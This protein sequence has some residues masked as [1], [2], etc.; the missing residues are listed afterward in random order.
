MTD[1]L[2][3]KEVV[4]KLD[5]RTTEEHIQNHYRDIF[6]LYQGIFVVIDNGV[7]LFN[8]KSGATQIAADATANELWTTD[9]HA[10]LP[11]NVVMMGV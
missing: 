11:D 8:V 5:E 4:Q 9:S 1:S 3:S 7:F 6:R 2:I 10:S